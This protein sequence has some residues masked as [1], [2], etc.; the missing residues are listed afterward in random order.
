MLR[1]IFQIAI[2]FVEAATYWL[3]CSLTVFGAWKWMADSDAAI[4]AIRPPAIRE[5]A[6]R[7]GGVGNLVRS[8]IVDP[9]FAQAALI[10]AGLV[11]AVGVVYLR[12]ILAVTDEEIQ[13]DGTPS[14]SH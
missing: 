14:T 6:E 2:G 8:I 1:F 4:R 9:E 13:N 7:S 10:G 3:L 5:L 12:A 11:I